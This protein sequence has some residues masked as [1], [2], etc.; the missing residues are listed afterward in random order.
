MQTVVITRARVVKRKDIMESK[1]PNKENN[2]CMIGKWLARIIE[3]YS[4]SSL[5]EE[6]ASF[7]EAIQ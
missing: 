2:I 7:D 3:V 6:T 1:A 5:R 4:P